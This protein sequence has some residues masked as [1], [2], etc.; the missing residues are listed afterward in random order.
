MI[1]GTFGVEKPLCSFANS[2]LIPGTDPVCGNDWAFST[3][4]KQDPHVRLGLS[5]ISSDKS[6]PVQ[7]IRG[8]SELLM[9]LLHVCFAGKN[10]RKKHLESLV[11]YIEALLEG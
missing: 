8:T 3:F 9:Y 10:R 7:K 11:H 2:D 1:Q 6:C 5:H 4:F